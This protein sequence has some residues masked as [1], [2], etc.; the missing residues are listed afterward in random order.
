MIQYESG[1]ID[2][3]PQDILECEYDEYA[4]GGK[5]K[6]SKAKDGQRT[7]KPYGWRWKNEAIE[8]G[9]IPKSAVLKTPS[10]YYRT[11]YPDLVYWENRPSKSDKKPSR[12]YISL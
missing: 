10:K 8:K 2:Y 4:K 12:K 9:L 11:K 6:H 3:V 1:I 5:V 7:A